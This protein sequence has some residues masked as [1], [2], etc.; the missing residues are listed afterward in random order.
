MGK[1]NLGQV[2]FGGLVAG[3]IINVVEGGVRELRTAFPPTK[4]PRGQST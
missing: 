2:I 1:I 3:V 4:L